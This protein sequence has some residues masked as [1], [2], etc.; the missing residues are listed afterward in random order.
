MGAP[1]SCSARLDGVSGRGSYTGRDEEDRHTA[2]GTRHICTYADS[3]FVFVFRFAGVENRDRDWDGR[4]PQLAAAGR[5]EAGVVVD[6][7][8][9]SWRYETRTVPMQQSGMSSS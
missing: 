5:G 2:H 1:S 4:G 7:A 8:L 3:R 9:G 6:E